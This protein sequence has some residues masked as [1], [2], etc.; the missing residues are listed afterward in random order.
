MN[1]FYQSHKRCFLCFFVEHLFS[2]PLPLIL[3]T[4]GSSQPLASVHPDKSLLLSLRYSRCPWGLPASH[5]LGSPLS[6]RPPSSKRP[7]A[8]RPDAP[9]PG[10]SAPCQHF[11][12]PTPL[13]RFWPLCF[14]PRPP[15]QS[16]P[17]HTRSIRPSPLNAGVRRP[18]HS[19]GEASR[20]CGCPASGG[21]KRMAGRRT[22]AAWWP[23][24]PGS[25]WGH[26]APH[27]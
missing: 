19:P 7:P 10:A 12:T 4:P 17:T 8:K 26:A 23:K 25:R 21:S 24:K 27:L 20:S 15:R 5:L 2:H 9:A 3:W 6:P 16:A 18:V 22:S 1:T 13:T 14:A 11:P